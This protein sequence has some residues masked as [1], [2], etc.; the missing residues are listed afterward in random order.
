MVVLFTVFLILTLYIYGNFKINKNNNFL[1]TIDEKVLVKI[2]SPN[3]DLEYNLSK[4][5]L[6]KGLKKL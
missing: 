3:F 4:K 6:K 5:K 2:V 1:K